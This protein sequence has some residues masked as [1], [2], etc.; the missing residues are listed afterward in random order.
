MEQ[1]TPQAVPVAPVEG[2][3]ALDQMTG[4]MTAN[5]PG[6]GAMTHDLSGLWPVRPGRLDREGGHSHAA[7]G[8]DLE[9][10]RS[11][12]QLIRL[13]ALR[14]QAKQ[15]EDAFWT[16]RCGKAD[17]ISSTGRPIRGLDLRGGDAPKWRRSARGLLSNEAL[18]EAC[19]TA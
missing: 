14:A 18:R 8:L 7:A 10:R 12:P 16:A 3:Q 11:S 4:A 17:R 5:T 6:L 2:G 1:P 9:L 13:R 19:A 15:F